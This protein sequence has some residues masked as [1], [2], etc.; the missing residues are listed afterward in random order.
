M[1]EFSNFFFWWD[2]RGK[3]IS[4]GEGKSE[5]TC[6]AGKEGVPTE[7]RIRAVKLVKNLANIE[8]SVAAIHAEGSLAAQKMTFL[9][10]ADLEAYK[11]AAKWACGIEEAKEHGNQK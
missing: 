10:I 7:Y 2:R 6:L 5:G 9:Q 4:S 8:V 3:G 11:A 1:E